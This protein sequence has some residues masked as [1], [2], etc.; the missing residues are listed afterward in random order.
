MTLDPTL[1]AVSPAHAAGVDT[2][3]HLL[4]L[5]GVPGAGKSTLI[6]QVADRHP[7]VRTLDPETVTRWLATRLPEV[8][9]RLYRPLVHLWHTIA[10]LVLVLVGPTVG[11]R[12]LLVHD[13]ATRPGRREL[14][15]RIAHAR[16]WRTSLVMIDVPRVAAI[17]G[18]HERGRLVSSGSFDRHWHRWL[19]DQPRLLTAATFGDADG[20]WDRVHVVDRARAGERLAT[21]L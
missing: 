4:L 1:A 13:P 16:G 20:S 12:T 11:H 7:D 10:T 14:L 3:P 15:G 17:D 21:L 5:G 9:Y 19:D 8:P 6:R 18:Q 2:R